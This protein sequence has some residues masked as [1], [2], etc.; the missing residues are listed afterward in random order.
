MP[1]KSNYL[2]DPPLFSLSRWL[3]P[4][5]IMRKQNWPPPPPRKPF[6]ATHSVR[7]KDTANLIFTL[8]AFCQLDLQNGIRCHPLGG[9]GQIWIPSSIRAVDAAA[10]PRNRSNFWTIALVRVTKI[11]NNRRNQTAALQA[12][13]WRGSRVGRLGQ[14]RCSEWILSRDSLTFSTYHTWQKFGRTKL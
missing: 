12:A 11:N 13:R 6:N 5:F 1:A 7:L 4:T 9:V 14:S 8:I 10:E 3:F 2:P